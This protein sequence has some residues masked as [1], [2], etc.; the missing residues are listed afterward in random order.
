MDA[1][2]TLITAA[3]VGIFGALSGWFF[4]RRRRTAHLRERFGAEY[5]RAVHDAG[6][7]N[8]AESALSAREK[9]VER[10][11]IHPLGGADAVRFGEG[12][13]TIQSKFVDDPGRAVTLA[14]RL[15]A[16]VMRARGYPVGD[17]EQRVEDISVDHAD[18][19]INYRAARELSDRHALGQAATEDLRQAMVHY[20]ALFRDLLQAAP[21]R[22][23]LKMEREHAGRR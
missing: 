15:V 19:V 10:L 1:N 11:H 3:A 7:L 4:W 2:T 17:F 14:D 18:L 12:W 8:T 22:P 21:Q 9:R 13:R 5:D 23:V 16:E 20:R 6:S